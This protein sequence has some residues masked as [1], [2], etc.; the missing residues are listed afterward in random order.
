MSWETPKTDWI[1]EDRFDAPNYNRIKNNLLYLY[2]LAISLYKSFSISDMGSDKDYSSFYYADEIN[3]LA[4]NL[5]MI[6]SN[7]YPVEIGEKITYVQ[8][9]AFI[10]YDDLNRIES[11]CLRIY[12]ILTEQKAN[13]VR[14]S[15]RLGNMKGV[16]C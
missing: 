1:S 14:L 9:Q 13:L 11:A 3:T 8:N 12:T 6:N 15:F 5:E 2:E 10:M 16:K 7:T 4:D